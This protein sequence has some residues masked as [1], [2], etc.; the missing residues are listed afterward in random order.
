MIAFT[1]SKS[2]T[3]EETVVESDLQHTNDLINLEVMQESAD[4]GSVQIDS[5]RAKSVTGNLYIPEEE[6]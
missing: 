6:N 3:G 1:G 4:R 5:F 2:R